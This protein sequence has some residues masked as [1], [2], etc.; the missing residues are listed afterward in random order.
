MFLAAKEALHNVVKHAAAREVWL[1]M[2]VRDDVLCLRIEDDGQ[3]M[4]NDTSSTSGHG[5]AN[6]ASRMEHIGGRYV[7]S[8]QPGQG[9]TVELTLPLKGKLP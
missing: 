3:G 9:T 5:S 4:A 6:M 8:S 2:A 1:H 7:R